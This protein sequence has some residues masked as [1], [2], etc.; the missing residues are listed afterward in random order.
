MP[1]EDV[2]GFKRIVVWDARTGKVIG[3]LDRDAVAGVELQVQDVPWHPVPPMLDFSASVELTP[4]SVALFNALSSEQERDSS[5]R[6]PARR[7][8]RGRTKR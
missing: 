6:S 5:A 8:R 1:E 7:T 2:L 3:E 4:E